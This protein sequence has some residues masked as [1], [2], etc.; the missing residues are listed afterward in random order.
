MV[1]Y[2]CSIYSDP[3]KGVF[4]HSVLEIK[5]LAISVFLM[6]VTPLGDPVDV[7][8]QEGGDQ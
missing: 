8:G 4:G 6:E 1:R 2:V 5:Q 7:V 3:K